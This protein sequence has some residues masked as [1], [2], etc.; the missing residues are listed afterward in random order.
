[1]PIFQIGKN[2]KGS[3]IT[4]EQTGIASTYDKTKAH[5]HPIGRY[6]SELA[7]NVPYGTCECIWVWYDNLLS[8]AT[9]L[10]VLLTA[11]ADGD[12][13]IMESGA[14]AITPGITTATEGGI[15][16]YMGIPFSASEATTNVYLHVK[17]DTGTVDIQKSQI[18]WSL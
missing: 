6:D 18:S 15:Q 12:V 2:L 7:Y 14:I 5:V 4:S 16:V 17:T 13:P 8:A 3:L 1:M 11:D 9:T 10:T